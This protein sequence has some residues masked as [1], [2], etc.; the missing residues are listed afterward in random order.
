MI[1]R[2]KIK[3]VALVG[4]IFSVVSLLVHLLLAQY[5][6]EDWALSTLGSVDDFYRNSG[7]QVR[8][9]RLWG[10]VK[11]LEA[12]QPHASP[13]NEY[14]VPK[15]QNN[16]YIYAKIYGGFENIR[17]S[18]C[19]LVTVSRLLNATLVIPEIQESTRSK[20]I[21]AKF[22]SFSYLYNE[23]QFI[24]ALTNDVIVVRSLPNSLKEARKGNKFPTISPK[25]S[26]PPSFYINEVL[27]K[28]KQSKVVG[29]MI[30]DGGC[31]QSIL[32]SS[33]V[34]YQRLRCRVAFHALNFRTEIQ[35]LGQ[36]IVR[37]LRAMGQRYLAF[38][39][40]L[41]RDTLAFHGCAELFQDVHTELIQYWRK[42]LIKRGPLRVDSLSRKN[43]GS[44][45]LMP[46]EVG[47]LL[48]AIGHPPN[49]LIYVAGSEIFGG[50]RVLIP[51]R[52]MYN[53]VDRTSL[54][55]KK[56]LLNLLGPETALPS[57]LPKP[58]PSKTEAQLIEEWK[59]AGPRPRPLP[60]PPARPFYRHEKEGWYGWVAETDKEPE[61]SPMDTR[62]QAHRL[63]WDALDY[64]VSVEADA[65]FPGFN[66]GGSGWPDFSSLVMG[67]R[68]YEMASSVTY[69]PN[70][71]I[72]A[73]L[74]DGIRDN[75][76]HPKR[77]WTIAVRQHL[78]KTLGFEGLIMQSQASKSVSFLSHPL[79]ECSCRTSQFPNPVKGKDGEL[80][81][82]SEDKCPDWMPRSNNLKEDTIDEADLPE[83]DIYP[84]EQPESVVA[85]EQDDE[86]DPDD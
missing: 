5:S 28:L 72:L 56:E 75:L 58:P 9:R 27:P 63:L 48:R 15:E 29:L 65:F 3:L 47:L 25:S 24:S 21:S 42:Q 67:Q 39:P 45:P 30:T 81:Y 32:P 68:I 17:T 34:E 7:E 2:S 16:G 69:R 10:P 14:P 77:N 33:M 46:E 83:D 12:L 59:K 11:S 43:N 22:K 61:P 4:A 76:Y 66:N 49:T 1:I 85:S 52:S 80:L 54:C 35:T 84:E 19:D 86:M 23:D 74:L 82:G 55:S 20:G 6:S 38:H 37:R 26:A 18:I 53:V 70:R 62:N 64:I 50:Q 60:P 44:C 78:N 8:N 79:P 57:D 31:L 40:G 71:K 41:V 51:L 36:Q 13:R 73:G